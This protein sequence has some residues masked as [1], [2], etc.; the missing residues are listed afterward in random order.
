MFGFS[1][2]PHRKGLLDG[3]LSVLLAPP[4]QEVGEDLVGVGV[5]GTPHEGGLHDLLELLGKFPEQLELLPDMERAVKPVIVSL[6]FHL[7][8]KY[9]TGDREDSRG[10]RHEFQQVTVGVTR[11][12]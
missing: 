11:A 4:G 10:V 5:P 8:S 6:K 2:S 7:I 9:F 3:P 12:T 1:V